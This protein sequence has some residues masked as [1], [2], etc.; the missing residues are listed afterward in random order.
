MEDAAFLDYLEQSGRLTSPD[1]VPPAYR[2][3]LLR[4]MAGSVDS[5]LAGAAGFAEM[6]NQAPDLSGRRFMASMVFEK[7]GHGERVLEL[8]QPFGADPDRY[9][10]L[11]A[12]HARVSRSEDLDSERRAGD[13]RLNVFH[14][15]L[16]GWPDA[17]VM[18]L[19]MGHASQIQLQELS[20]C[21]Y[22]P[23]A[24]V[25]AEI[26]PVEEGHL[27]EGIDHLGRAIADDMARQEA[28]LSLS[29]WRPR[30]SASFGGDAI[31]PLRTTAPLRPA[32]RP[33]ATCAKVGCRF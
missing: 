15:P 29:Y 22:Q 13:M 2:R 3:E 9:A 28:I 7:L 12:W 4:L 32:I 33:T 26:L 20:R 25:I 17:L 31:I 1:N 19:A 16:T 21:S 6:I 5:E 27:L 30:V 18:N 23:L 10:G 24:D 11:H 8:M 14:Y